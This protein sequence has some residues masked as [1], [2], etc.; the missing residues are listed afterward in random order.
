MTGILA[1][2]FLVTIVGV[3]LFPGIGGGPVSQR[4]QCKNNLK[5]IG[6]ALYSY[7]E[8][9]GSFPP[10]YIADREGRP[11]HSW[12]VLLLPYLDQTPLYQEYR[13]D[14]PWNGPNNRLLA[15]RIPSLFSCP[16]ETS[17]KG[18]QAATMTSYVAVIGDETVWPG[19]RSTKFQDMTDGTANTIAVVEVADSGIDWME[20]RDLHLLQM[21]AAINSRSGQGISSRH[22]GGVNSLFCDG[23]VHFLPDTLPIESL[24]ALVTRGGGERVVDF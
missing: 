24:R 1:V 10:A 15:S 3:C 13:F 16:I 12:R 11:M 18:K 8:A 20:P 23:S 4:S 21:A 2:L 5:Q 14:E 9:Y 6:M 19:N 22:T 7:H 17:A